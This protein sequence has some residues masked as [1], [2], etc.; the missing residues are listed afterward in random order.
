V[1]EDVV[2]E[3]RHLRLIE[4]VAEVFAQTGQWPRYPYVEAVL[5]HRYGLEFDDAAADL[6]PH[7]V[8]WPGGLGGQTEVI[9][10]VLALAEVAAID[11]DLR[12]F[13]AVIAALAQREWAYTPPPHGCGELSVDRETVLAVAGIDDTDQLATDKLLALVDAEYVASVTGQRDG[14]WSLIVDRRI[15]AFRG[16]GSVSD[17]RARRRVPTVRPVVNAEDHRTSIFIIM[18]FE[19]EW[20]DAVHA[21]IQDACAAVASSLP[22]LVWR[23]ADGISEPGRITDQI[24]TAI[25][26]ADL[27]VADTTDYNPNVMFELGFADAAGKPIVLLNQSLRANPFDIKDWRAIVYDVAQLGDARAELASFIR[28]GLAAARRGG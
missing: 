2:F 1:A 22:G 14:K 7:V 28:G 15:R 10:G 3:P 26:T 24:V 23:R 17:Y 6:P 20:S 21:M 13:V 18:P 27:I 12:R 4:T 9:A 8:W 25:E 16:V 19:R 5:D 11:E